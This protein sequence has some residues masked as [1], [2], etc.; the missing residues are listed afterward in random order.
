MRLDDLG[1]NINVED[2]RGRFGGRGVRMGG[3]LSL[4]SL[5]LIA[6][7]SLVF[8][9][10]PLDLI[11]NSGQEL[12]V[13]ET[14]NAPAGSADAGTAC[15]KDE[16]S[17]LSCRVLGSTDALWTAQ[18]AAAGAQ[19]RKPTL[20]F[21]SQSDVSGCGAA[22]AA[23]GPFYCPSD[24][25][26]YLDTDFYRELSERFGAAGDFAQA[27]VIA[28]E[29]GHHVQHLM[30]LADQV[31]TAQQRAGQSEA[32]R[33]QVKMELQADCFAGMWAGQNRDRIEPGDIEEG[34]RAANA[35][36]DDTLQRQAGQRVTPDSFTHGSSEQRKA[37]LRRG[38]ESPD[39]QQCDTF[40][41]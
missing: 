18:F 1:T 19:Y 12:S 41:R 37:W 21:Y 32:N 34:M 29:V 30:G 11:S 9:V 2:R 27:Y 33:L 20:V 16:V 31:R 8:G 40:N 7:A 14:A 25:R 10:N 23:M 38:L 36:G 13:D 35:I 22:Q 17:L 5:A 4:G 6:I 3:G 15:R 26:I 28:H 24:E 39:P